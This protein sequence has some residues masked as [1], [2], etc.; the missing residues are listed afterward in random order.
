MEWKR[1]PKKQSSQCQGVE[2]EQPR[3]KVN[4]LT[5]AMSVDASELVKTPAFKNAIQNASVL[6][7]LTTKN[8][9]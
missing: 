2:A 5:G 6:Q 9:A 7:K 4:W 1:Q 3:V 8:S